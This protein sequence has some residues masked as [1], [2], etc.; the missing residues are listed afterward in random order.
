MIIKYSL[1]AN[2][3]AYEAGA[4]DSVCTILD[5]VK[6]VKTALNAQ[7]EKYISVAFRDPLTPNMTL[8]L[9]NAVYVMNDN[10]KTIEVV[11]PNK[12]TAETKT[13]ADTTNE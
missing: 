7:G 3:E 12:L 2:P 8:L 13:A 5:G 10:G 4:D 1:R 6:E 11:T 9:T